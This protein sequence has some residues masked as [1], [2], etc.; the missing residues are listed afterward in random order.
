MF[1]SYGKRLV[2]DNAPLPA[3]LS[4]WS[5]EVDFLKPYPN[6][7]DIDVTGQMKAKGWTV[8]KMYQTADD[9]YQSLGLDPMPQVSII[10]Y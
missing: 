7:P 6:K 2:K 4:F 1:L 10:L 9:F 8:K 3:H 5:N